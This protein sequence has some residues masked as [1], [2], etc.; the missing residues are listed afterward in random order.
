LIGVPALRALP[1]PRKFGIID[2]LK[3]TS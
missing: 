3:I 2:P 1:V